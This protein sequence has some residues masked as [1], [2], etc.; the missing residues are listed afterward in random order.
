MPYH[1]H[2][3][4]V[5]WL[6]EEAI[7]RAGS[8]GFFRAFLVEAGTKVMPGDALIET[9]DPALN[10]QL[11]RSEARV[12]ELE[13]EYN[14]EFVSDKTKA[15][16]ARDKLDGERANLAVAR[17]RMAELVVHARTDGIFVVPQRADMPGR[18]YKKGDL[19]GYVIGRAHPLARVVVPQEAIDEVRLGTD[20]V[21]VRLSENP[22]T[23]L[24]G[25]VVREVPAGDATLPSPALS[26]QSGGAIATDPR[27]TKTSKA[28]QRFFQFDV[29]LEDA[30]RIDHFGQRLFVRF[31]HRMEPLAVQWYRSIRL[32][33]LTA[34]NV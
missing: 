2:A 7:V 4:G 20:D 31:E 34:F 33:F 9:Y 27:E 25:R 11:Q 10:S 22:E 19:L 21:R 29:E 5:L 26:A 8:G 18:Y 13:A 32:L 1:S 6:P 28:L 23:A 30:D 17:E 24:H 15:Q 14:A 3:E 16:I 12:A